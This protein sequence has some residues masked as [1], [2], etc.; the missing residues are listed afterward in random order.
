MRQSLRDKQILQ[1]S[2]FGRGI[3]FGWK[4]IRS[5]W[6]IVQSSDKRV[7][8]IKFPNV[9]LWLIADSFCEHEKIEESANLDYRIVSKKQM[10]QRQRNSEA[11]WVSRLWLLERCQANEQVSGGSST[12]IKAQ[13]A[14]NETK[15]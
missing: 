4:H 12:D 11:M 14:N 10:A 6:L 15:F 9:E 8:P 7:D 3:S 2:N 13:F 1:T 5:N